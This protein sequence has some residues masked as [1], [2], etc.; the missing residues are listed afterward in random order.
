MGVLE[1]VGL[2]NALFRKE[3]LPDPEGFAPLAR[4]TCSRETDRQ[5]DRPREVTNGL[6]VYVINDEN[7]RGEN[8]QAKKRPID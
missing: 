3:R 7:S 5:P 8:V 4:A 2:C 6:Q 1:T